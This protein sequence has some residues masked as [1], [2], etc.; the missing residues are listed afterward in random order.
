MIFFYFVGSVN[1]NKKKNDN[2]KQ[3]FISFS[4]F[5]I[6]NNNNLYFFLYKIEFIFVDQNRNYSILIVNCK[7][8][9]GT[10]FTFY[11]FILL[12]IRNI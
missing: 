8:F 4:S 3:F 6:I 12:F 9:N 2:N 5:S 7:Y 11:L 10:K 1:I